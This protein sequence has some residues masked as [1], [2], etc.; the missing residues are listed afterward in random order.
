MRS[1]HSLAELA[2]LVELPERTVRYYIQLGLVDRPVGETRAARYGER[3]LAQ[4]VE[5]RKWQHAGLSLERIGELL[6]DARVKGPPPRRRGAGTVEVWSHLVIAEGVELTIN[7]GA[8]GLTPAQVRRFFREAT[9]A[10]ANLRK[11]RN[12]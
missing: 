3:H 2:A 8:A 9:A 5:I 6:A 10:Y 12:P 4:L 1:T 7:P 11:E